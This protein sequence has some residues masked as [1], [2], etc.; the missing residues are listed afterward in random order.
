MFP[1]YVIAALVGLL[2]IVT[3][4]LGDTQIAPASVAVEGKHYLE[5][6]WQSSSGV[7]VIPHICQ[8]IMCELFEFHTHFK[9]K[10]PGYGGCR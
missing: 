2:A 9:A 10:W 7:E 8:F 4:V 1:T 5:L 3:P 6:A